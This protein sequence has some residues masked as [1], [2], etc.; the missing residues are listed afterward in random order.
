MDFKVF[1]AL[2]TVVGLILS[3]HNIFRNKA[4]LNKLLEFIC[5]LCIAT[6]SIVLFEKSFIKSIIIGLASYLIVHMISVCTVI[7]AKKIVFSL[8]KSISNNGIFSRKII[9]VFGK[10]RTLQ[11]ISYMRKLDYGPRLKEGYPYMAG[12]KH[13]KTRTK[14]DRKGFPIFKTYCTVW[15]APKDWKKDR[16]AHFSIACKKLYKKAMRN[17]KFAR[18][19]T[20]KELELFKNGIVPDKYT[21]HHHQDTG[22]LQLVLRRIHS[23]VNHIGGFAIWG[24]EED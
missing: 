15:L 21:W 4:F 3:M 8:R 9:G 10:K 19:F 24:P 7:I 16:D 2:V 22:R 14:F 1:T 5:P 23:K 12:K 6:T 18:R 13:P 17:K 20:K 11:F